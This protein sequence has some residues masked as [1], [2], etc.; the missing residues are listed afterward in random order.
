[1]KVAVSFPT[2]SN[3]TLQVQIAIII[4]NG[5]TSNIHFSMNI[6]WSS[7]VQTQSYVIQ[8]AFG[9]KLK[10]SYRT[11]DDILVDLAGTRHCCHL[12]LVYK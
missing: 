4:S 3:S 2:S 1:M 6:S 12:E 8:H 9:V 5:V 11:Y 10:L 7:G